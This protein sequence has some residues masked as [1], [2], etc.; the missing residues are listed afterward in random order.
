MSVP[1]YHI[2]S[3]LSRIE[4]RSDAELVGSLSVRKKEYGVG[5]NDRDQFP[6]PFKLFNLKLHL[7][8]VSNVA[9]MD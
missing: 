7:Q 1:R 2:E 6:I 4:S 8:A 9:S 3:D 5:I